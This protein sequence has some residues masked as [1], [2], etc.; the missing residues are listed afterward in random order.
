L[1]QQQGK[2]NNENTKNM[3]KNNAFSLSG[4]FYIMLDF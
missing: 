2:N 3:G 1:E 4:I